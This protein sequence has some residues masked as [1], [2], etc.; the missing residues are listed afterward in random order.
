MNPPVNIAVTGAAGQIGYALLF[1]IAAG[2]LLGRNQPIRLQ[3]LEVPQA[4]AALDGVIMELRDCAYPRLVDIIA[5]D[6]P[7]IAFKDARYVFLVGAKPRSAGMQ[8]SDLLQANAA[9]FKVQG[10]ALDKA[11]A[12]DV[13][14]V[15]VGNPANTNALIAQ[16][17]APS[18]DPW[19]FSAMT[20]LDQNRAK[21]RLATKL[22]CGVGQIRRL[23]VWGNHSST[24]YPDVAHA[25]VDGKSVQLDP[26]WLSSEFIPGVAERGA[27]IIK[28]RGASSA[29]SAAHAALEHMRDWIGGSDDWVSMALPSKGDYDVPRGL[30]Y[31]F[32][33]QCDGQRT[34]IVPGLELSAEARARLDASRRELEEELAAIRHL[35]P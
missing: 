30:V 26:A 20:R 7:E 5:T 19:C 17:H 27:A 32:P 1:R 28:A 14:V 31:S 15:V 10:Q 24:Q 18:L 4:R 2:G 21:A 23:C 35:L 12:R 3:L 22:G 29:A 13:R 33:M 11:A 6:D 9:I 8:R 16:R 25:T 34:V